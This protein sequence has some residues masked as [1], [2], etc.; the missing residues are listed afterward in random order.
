MSCKDDISV[1]LVTVQFS[2]EVVCILGIL[3]HTNCIH[4][5]MICSVVFFCVLCK[6]FVVFLS[7]QSFPM[8][9]HLLHFSS[10]V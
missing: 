5:L 7:R 10:A 3:I 2:R 1:V 9:C 4:E 6:L 8:A